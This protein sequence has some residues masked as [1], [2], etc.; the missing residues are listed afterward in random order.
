M[1]RGTM[2][3][4]EAAE[5]ELT[6]PVLVTVDDCWVEELMGEEDTTEE[7]EAGAEVAVAVT[8]EETT[9]EETTEGEEDTADC[10]MPALEFL[11]TSPEGMP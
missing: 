6:V 10:W 1:P 4:M 11:M 9:F 7:E 5:D 3:G 2:S 8:E